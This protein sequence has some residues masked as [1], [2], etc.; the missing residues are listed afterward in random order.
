MLLVLCVNRLI[1]TE[2]VVEDG[3]D[4]RVFYRMPRIC[5]KLIWSLCLS[6]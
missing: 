2:M 3:R 4:L 6:P 1:E 5:G